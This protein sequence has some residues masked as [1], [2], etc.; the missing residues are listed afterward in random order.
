[1]FPWNLARSAE[2]VFS[3]W[4]MKRLCKFLLKKKLGKFILGDIDLN[5][6]DVQLSAGTIQLSDLALNVDYLNQKFGSATTVVMK[7]GSIGSLLVKM[8]WK[9]DGC[10]VEVDEFELVFA[11]RLC[12]IP[13]NGV[14]ASTSGQESQ[15]HTY[16][17]SHNL[18]N[19][20]HDTAGSAGTSTLDVHEGVK[21]VALMVKWL[22]TNFHVRTR[23]LIL[24]FDPCFAAEKD[25]CLNSSL[26]LRL[27]EI[28]CGTC[29]SDS[30]S[31]DCESV[32][33]NVLGLCRMTNFLKF[34]GAVL[35]F[36]PMNGV[37]EKKPF[38]CSSGTSAGEHSSCSYH[39]RTIPVITGERGGFSGNLKL[40][41]PWDNGSLDIHKV[42]ADAYIDPLQ[43][44]FH[45]TSIRSFLCLWEMFRDIGDKNSSNIISRV[46]E[47]DKCNKQLNC[48]L[49]NTD[50]CRLSDAFLGQN[51]NS[52]EYLH[53]TDEE[54]VGEALL[55]ESHLIPDWVR[56]QTEKTEEPDFGASVE[57][58]FECFDGLR[59]SQS[60]LGGSGI[61]NW[62]SSIFSAVTTASTLASGSVHIPSD[63]QLHIETKIRAA[64]VKISVSFFFTDDED[65]HCSSLKT[66]GMTA[67]TFVHYMSAHFDDLSLVVQVCH[68]EMNFE[69]TVQHIGLAD[70]FSDGDR[71]LKDS[72]GIQEIQKSVQN[73]IPDLSTSSANDELRNLTCAAGDVSMLFDNRCTQPQT[74]SGPDDVVQV[75]LLQTIGQS[76]CQI[77]IGASSEL[78]TGP[79]SFSLKLPY[80]IFWLDLDLMSE[81]SELLKQVSES[82]ERTSRVSPYEGY[83]LSSKQEMKSSSTHQNL[84]GNVFLP[85]TRIIMCFPYRKVGGFRSYSSWREFIALDL[86]S[87]TLPGKKNDHVDPT[88]TACSKNNYPLKSSLS[89]HLNFGDLNIYLITSESKENVDSSSG[90]KHKSK[91]LAQNIMSISCGRQTCAV[92]FFRQKSPG[93]ASTDTVIKAKLF[94]SSDINRCRDRLKGKD[95]EFASVSTVKG[96]E[97]YDDIQRK[98]IDSS[99]FFIHAQI[100]SVTAN[101]SKSQYVYVHNFLSQLIDGFSLMASVQV[102]MRDK[103]FASQ[104]SVLVECETLSISISTEVEESIKGPFQ[105]ELPGSWHSLKLEV[106]KFGLFSASDIGGIAST[107][108]LRVFHGDGN[109]WGYISGLTREVLL[110]SCN[111]ASMG[112]GGGD[113]SNVLSSKRSGSDII[114][115]LDPQSLSNHTS[116]TVWGGT[117]VAV[118]G[119]LDW[120]DMITSFFSLSSPETEES[121]DISQKKDCKESLPFE[122]SFVLN[123][124]DIGLSYEPYLGFNKG[125]ET[126]Y[127]SNVNE[128]I[129]E[130]HIA[131]LLAA[132]SLRVSNTSFADSNV[133]DYIITV[134]D[135]GLLLSVV[136]GPE[137]ACHI[138]S[139]E[140]LHKIGYVKVAQEANIEAVVRINCEN[141]NLW[142]V[143]CSESQIVLNTCHDTVSGLIR[144]A[145]QLQQIF[146]PNIE[147]LAVHLQTRWENAQQANG[148]EEISMAE[149]NSP[150]LTS[151]VLTSIADVENI[152]D[153]ICEDA[154]PLKKTNDAQADSCFGGEYYSSHSEAQHL[155]ETLPVS[156]SS[157]AAGLEKSD[158]SEEKMPK[159]I[160]DYLLYD[161][162]C[163]SEPS[164]KGNSPNEVAKCKSSSAKNT[165]GQK[166]RNGWYDE[167]SLRIL[168]NHVSKDTG[169][170]GSLQHECEASSC[171]KVDENGKIKGHIVFNNMNVIWRLYAGSDWKNFEKTAQCSAG[172]C[173]RD[174]TSC[175][176]LILSGVGFEYD[177]YP[178]GGI[179][180]SRLSIAVK[181]IFLSDCSND[182]PW[183]LVLG[184]YQSKKCARKSSSKAF[185]LDLE[186]V[187]PEPAIPLEEYRLRVAFLPIRLHLHQTQLDFL[188]TFFGGTNSTSNSSH[189]AS[190][191]L[192]EPISIS[193][194]KT[195]I[196][197]HA[198]TMEALLPYFQKFEIWPMLVRV[199]YSPCR[200][201]LAALRGGKYVELVN[202]VPWKGVEMS[203]KHVQ[204]I[205]VYGWGCVCESIIGEWL[206]D[207]SQNQIHKLLKGLPPIRSLVAVGSGAA[208]LVSLPVK[209]YKKDHKLL[210]GMQRGTIAFLRS[211]SLEAIGLG[212]HLAAGAHEILLQ[213]EYILTTIPPCIPLS[214]NDRRDCVRSNQP[215]DARQG[216]QQAYDSIS[217]G[218]SKSASVLVRTPLKRYQR[219]AGMGTAFVTAVKAAP[220]AAIA[221]AS[222][223]ARALHCALLGVRN[224]LDPGRK[225]ESL[226]KYLGTSPTQHFM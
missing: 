108:F 72:K 178:D 192:Y 140:H 2:A 88:S 67:G 43:L 12:N 126:I 164:L 151:S 62:T 38:P 36:L 56:S 203:L 207:I 35:E 148:N 47:F 172:T 31:S 22:L 171:K 105:Y 118:G 121:G 75:E 124:V 176:E 216:I 1:M 92:S 183:K 122:C 27:T 226:D 177:I 11:P 170:I 21:T 49:S 65:R 210:K 166:E 70:C 71:T 188:I 155:Y 94:S 40:C 107:S 221:P 66:D 98:M 152:M 9:G 25:K 120:L 17:V 115:L 195:V 77:T 80:F 174:T 194:Q 182:A 53:L 143:E 5:Q 106:Q 48:A 74:F 185:K 211:I 217:D 206:E 18:P 39:N 102:E 76:Q 97:D 90:V 68:H 87:S 191:N 123:M 29:I 201:D 225:K 134:Q 100:S 169:Q 223:T 138:Y 157:L 199:D 219:G 215:E 137:T 142:Q 93:V 117:I 69:A 85:T 14:G 141:G 45:P 139:V 52:T 4:A 99:E 135:L 202:L 160:E 33:G 197:G 213:A 103:S 224:S 81:I 54:P 79:T 59:N 198:I 78:F 10:C 114:H 37:D 101:L 83:C 7:E 156:E 89:L 190:Q 116:I 13:G 145:T 204:G 208:K 125:S 111:N 186:A 3:R 132:S 159:F 91:F 57:Q 50:S 110:I 175:L 154:F 6:L 23:K 28:E 30:V 58:F 187:R 180:V 46:T 196:G 109:L 51:K 163:L 168:E 205:G 212:V 24:A 42:E 127:S 61:W 20:D 220:S 153:E 8:P 15:D 19:I 189:D 73:A 112:R 149:G 34:Q 147:E 104:T 184:Y 119:R 86:S 44:K 209:S 113:G 150:P 130:Q 218:L 131:C 96:S 60:A 181:D 158:S 193:K 82:F 162:C 26:V 41:I 144:L 167:S 84:T 64:I 55:S 173:G 136:C 95:F 133:S 161:F 214:V 63:Q 165:D 128:V 129:D 16:Y 146:C 179:H 200:V 222:A 32:S